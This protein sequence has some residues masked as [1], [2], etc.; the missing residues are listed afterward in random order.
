MR[1]RNESLSNR[2]N[3]LDGKMKIRVEYNVT[4]P[5]QYSNIRQQLVDII[6]VSIGLKHTVY[7]YT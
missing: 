3:Y 1:T 7:S 6:R 5:N 4:K 2:K